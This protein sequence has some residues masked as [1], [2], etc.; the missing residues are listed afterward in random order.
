MSTRFSRFR[1]WTQRAFGRT[2]TPRSPVRTVKPDF[3]RL[4]DRAVPATFV[5]TNILDSQNDS[6][7]GLSL[8]QAILASNANPG[9][10]KITFNIPFSPS[11]PTIPGDPNENYFPIVLANTLPDLIDQAGVFIDATTQP[12]FNKYNPLLPIDDPINAKA[13]RP[14]VQLLPDPNPG[15][16][17][18]E[19]GAFL[20]SGPN[21]VIRGFVVTG[22]PGSGFNLSG[23]GAKNNIILNTW[24]NTDIS[25]TKSWN[26]DPVILSARPPGTPPELTNAGPFP[27]SNTKFV[28]N[29]I[30]LTN[31][32]SSN[33]IGGTTDASGVPLVAPDGSL[34]G[35]G[36]VITRSSDPTPIPITPEVNRNVI[37]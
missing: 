22:F 6:I 13:T 35:V 1:S 26:Q 21:N 16:F 29:G 30:A 36:G 11:L 4:E 19:V 24:I 10:D 37:S 34:I 28:L 23:E 27:L 15:A 12:R 25:G 33:I 9:F 31:G 5:V 20:I 3:V 14:N 17:P 2:E 8:R 7:G 32:A 18:N